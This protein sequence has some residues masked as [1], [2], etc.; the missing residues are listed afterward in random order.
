MDGLPPSGGHPAVYDLDSG[1]EYSDV[2]GVYGDDW[3]WVT[4]PD[5]AA[6]ALERWRRIVR[7]IRRVWALRRR[8]GLLGG[9]LRRYRGLR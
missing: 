9:T 6:L 4:P 3:D 1:D 7:H 2:S 8:W 5:A